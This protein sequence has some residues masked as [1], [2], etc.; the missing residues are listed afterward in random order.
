MV[1]A[2]HN[3]I[4]G[5]HLHQ[6]L[7]VNHLQQPL[8]GVAAALHNNPRDADVRNAA[9]NIVQ[10]PGEVAHLVVGHV[11]VVALRH[12]QGALHGELPLLRVAV[13]HAA[14]VLRLHEALPQYRAGGVGQ[15][16]RPVGVGHG[17]QVAPVE[18]CHPVGCQPV[19]KNPDVAAMCSDWGKRIVAVVLLRSERLRTTFQGDGTARA[20]TYVDGIGGSS[21]ERLERNAVVGHTCY[22]LIK[23]L[24]TPANT[25]MTTASPTWN[26]SYLSSSYFF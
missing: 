17:Q 19:V 6:V 26:Q 24:M 4:V 11:D 23:A 13:E 14:E 25:N 3:H 12:G 8:P 10:Q 18:G 15:R 21:A 20:A 5:I 16:H 1:V 9:D 2:G 7:P 22:E